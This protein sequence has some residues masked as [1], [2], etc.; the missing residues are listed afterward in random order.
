MKTK[1]KRIP[2]GIST[3]VGTALGVVLY[4][5]FLGAT[6][7]IDWQRALFVGAFIGLATAL[8]PRKK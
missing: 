6:G 2:Q 5:R 3:A 1:L 8:W 4:S 7:E